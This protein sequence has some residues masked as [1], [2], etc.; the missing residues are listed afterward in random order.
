MRPEP[1]NAWKR[2]AC[3]HGTPAALDCPTCELHDYAEEW[4][5]WA[6]SDEPGPA[7]Q[8]RPALLP[9]TL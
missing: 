6:W 4:D 9:V 8:Y 2:P 1:R 5:V 7:P 3:P